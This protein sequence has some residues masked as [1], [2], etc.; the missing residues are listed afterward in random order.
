MADNYKVPID[1]GALEIIRKNKCN[2]QTKGSNTILLNPKYDVIKELQKA[3]Y[4]PTLESQMK[5]LADVY[6]ITTPKMSCTP[7]PPK[8]KKEESVKKE[9]ME[10]G[11][12]AAEIS[13]MK[14]NAVKTQTVYVKVGKTIGMKAAV[15]MSPTKNE[16]CT[17]K[18][19]CYIITTDKVGTLDLNM[20]SKAINDGGYFLRTVKGNP[21]A[22]VEV[23]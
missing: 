16:E 21:I 8:P 20:V 22:L 18:V 5:S 1:V 14:Q 17:Q 9:K 13:G 15:A 2:Y 12:S 10:E 19:T 6:G 3:G 4:K 23:I 7:A 11:L